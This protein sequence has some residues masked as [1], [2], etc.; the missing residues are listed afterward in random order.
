MLNTKSNKVNL[1][2]LTLSVASGI[3]CIVNLTTIRK[4]RCLSVLVF[5]IIFAE[6][7]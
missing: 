7:F 3:R 1:S 2:V 4:L 6:M 5:V